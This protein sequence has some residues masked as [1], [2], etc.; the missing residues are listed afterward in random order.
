MVTSIAVILIFVGAFLAFRN[1]LAWVTLGTLLLTFIMTVTFAVLSSAPKLTDE[2]KYESRTIP[3]EEVKP[4]SA[5]VPKENEEISIV[6][7]CVLFLLISIFLYFLTLGQGPQMASFGPAIFL[8]FSLALIVIFCI[9]AACYSNINPQI[10]DK[11]QAS[12]R[13]ETPWLEQKPRSTTPVRRVRI[14]ETSDR[15]TSLASTSKG[16]LFWQTAGAQESTQKRITSKVRAVRGGE[17]IGGRFR[18]KVKVLNESP[19]TINDVTVYILSYP[20]D[21]LILKTEDDDVFFSKIEP[22][23]FRSPSFDFL[24]TQDCVRGEIVAGVSYVDAS[25]KAHTLTTESYT[26]R[27]VCDLL[28]PEAITPKRFELKLKELES[29]EILLKVG[30]WTPEEMQEKTLRVLSDSNFHEVSSDESV[31]DDVLHFR[32]TG[33]A[34]GKYTGKNIGAEIFITGRAR[35]KGASCRIRVAGEDDAMILPAI[36]DLKERLSAY[37]CP[38]CGSKLT[39]ENVEE[40]KSGKI[41]RCPFCNVSIGR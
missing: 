1:L 24:P 30:E 36:D 35:Q 21:T 32:V 12:S 6:A 5:Q 15:Q 14:T 20:R 29:G 3:S 40:L 17:I 31:T 16:Q 10:S 18:F 28:Q 7:V 39:L 19:Y 41:V 23:G 33:W 38:M 22:Q 4:P 34:K 27:A 8:T 9:L 11:E 13:E 26:I 2:E 37:L 25:G